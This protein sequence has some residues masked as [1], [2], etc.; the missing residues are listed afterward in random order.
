MG[1]FTFIQEK[2][3]YSGQNF[4]FVKLLYRVCRVGLFTDFC[5]K[6]NALR[7]VISISVEMIFF[8]QVV[9]IIVKRIVLESISLYLVKKSLERI[10]IEQDH[11]ETFD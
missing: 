10:W 4:L 3:K 1:Y 9:S 2:F 11:L 7:L 5:V 8:R 6:N